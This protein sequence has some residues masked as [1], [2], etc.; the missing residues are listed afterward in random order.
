MNR[1][2]TG[3][4]DI[5]KDDIR[6]GLSRA[7]APINHANVRHVYIRA[8][9]PASSFIRTTASPRGEGGRRPDEGSTS[10][11]APGR[12]DPPLLR[13]QRQHPPAS[14][15]L[16]RMPRHP[17]RTIE[18]Q[19]QSLQTSIDAGRTAADRNRLGQFATP[20]PLAV[21][22]AQA[23]HDLVGSRRVRFADPSIGTGSFFSAA[24]KVFGRKRI[25]G[26]C[27][28]ELDAEFAD[29]A[30]QLWSA[31][32]LNVITGDFTRVVAN[33]TCPPSP[34]LILANPPYVRHHHLAR[35][36]KQRLQQLVHELAGVR[37]SGLAGLYVYFLLLATAWMANDG[38]AA[39]LIPSEWMDV[40]YGAA[41]RGFLATRVTLERVHRFDPD[42]TQFG[43]ALVSS[44]VL[45]FRKSP[46]TARHAVMFTRGG[47]FA[48]PRATQRA[49]LDSLRSEPKWTTFPAARINGHRAKRD[50]SGPTLGELFQIR[51]GIATGCNQ[52]FILK[53]DEAQ[54]LGLPDECLR[55]ILPSPRL[56]KSTIIDSN[57]D[58]YLPLDP[59]LCVI[60]TDLPADILAA[61]HPSLWAYLQTGVKQGVDKGYLARHRRPWYR[62]E[63]RDPAPFLCT[64][65]GRGSGE[66]RPF[67]FIWNKSHATATNLYLLLTPIGP[68]AAMLHRYPARARI[69][70][71]LLNEITGDELRRAGRVYGGGLHKI[72]PRE[73]GGMTALQLVKR[74][75]ELRTNS[76]RAHKHRYGESQS[77]T[78]SPGITAK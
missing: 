64:Y 31:A 72:E 22:I 6:S 4:C 12:H 47:S 5:V 15:G 77:S 9:L 54:R 70:H 41:L 26:A 23:A 65:M 53:R 18:S 8:L 13:F 78:V 32:G 40:N 46:P 37:V 2:I 58:G 27:G 48:R 66:Q 59:Q 63:Q 75:E 44:A 21:Q 74:W 62:Q 24:L 67:R 38:V 69:V 55:P 56:L 36:D 60:D 73:L 29:A 71:E 39:W 52:F 43:D 50:S 34:D 1:I 33:G 42:D 3:F 20:H 16:S 35:E 76:T 28:I 14:I 68:L 30:R 49:S 17:I 61:K 45:L 25:V 10:I 11:D 19:R 7:Y 57:A 51:R